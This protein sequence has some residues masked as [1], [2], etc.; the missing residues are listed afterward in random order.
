MR[1]SLANGA[2][3]IVCDGLSFY[4]SH[5]PRFQVLFNMPSADP[6]LGPAPGPAPI[7]RPSSAA[8]SLAPHL[9]LEFPDSL[10]NDVTIAHRLLTK[11]SKGSQRITSL[12]NSASAYLHVAG[13]DGPSEESEP[14]EGTQTGHRSRREAQTS[15]TWTSSSGEV[16][17]EQDEVEDR[18]DFVQEYNRL[19]NKVL[20][21]PMT[22]LSLLTSWISMGFGQ[23]CQMR[24]IS[25]M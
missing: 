2:V 4:H 23:W 1:T 17:S 25:S 11:R 18:T 6:A 5:Y 15:N 24:M 9:D 10:L 7:S 16:F 19:A 12:T 21:T 13:W 8:L 20:F 14:F 22:S 3:I